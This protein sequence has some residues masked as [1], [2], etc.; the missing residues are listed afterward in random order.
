MKAAGAFNGLPQELRWNIRGYLAERKSFSMLT[1]PQ[2]DS[3][4]K[5]LSHDGTPRLQE[6]V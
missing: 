2:G 5:Q 3:L 1:K 6:S 4:I